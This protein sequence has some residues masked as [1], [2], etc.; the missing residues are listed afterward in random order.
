MS[1]SKKI[2]S[3]KDIIFIDNGAEDVAVF[4]GFFDFILHKNMYYKQQEPE[5]NFMILNSASFFEKSL[6]KMQEHTSVHLY[7]DNDK[8]G[9]KCTLR[10][11]ALDKQKFHDERQLYKQYNDLNDWLVQI[12]LSQKQQV[13]Q[14]P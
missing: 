2:S 3:L 9:Q 4:N 10:A 11:L 1:I 8:T 5:R 7:L 12:G 14:Q 13:K 6:T